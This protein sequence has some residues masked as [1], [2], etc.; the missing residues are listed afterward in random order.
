M[1]TI[2]F[3]GFNARTSHLNPLKD[4][5]KN[6]SF[7]VVLLAVF[8]LQFIFVTFGGDV[9]SVTS[10]SLESWLICAGLSFLIIPIDMIRKAIMHRGK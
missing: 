6:K 10:L 8:L 7:I 4:L 1:M 2:A 9:L 3:N 5:S